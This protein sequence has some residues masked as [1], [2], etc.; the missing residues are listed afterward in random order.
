MKTV[1]G[2]GPFHST[3]KLKNK[4]DVL[5]ISQLSRLSGLGKGLTMKSSLQGVELIQNGN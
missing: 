5:G 3:I 4:A 1:S 2:M